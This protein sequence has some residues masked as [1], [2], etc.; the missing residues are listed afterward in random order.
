MKDKKEKTT[1]IEIE[2]A[3]AFLLSLL[4]IKVRKARDYHKTCK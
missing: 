4:N 1:V 2:E 3:A